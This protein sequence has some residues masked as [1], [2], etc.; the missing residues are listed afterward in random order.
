MREML[1]AIW[2]APADDEPRLVYA[3]WLLERG[4]PRG[5]LIQVQIAIARAVGSAA[6]NERALRARERQLLEAH[7][8]AW[9][10]TPFDERIT[11]AF[12]RG[13]PT[14]R[15]G[16]AGLF[17]EHGRDRVFACHR[18]FL[19]GTVITVSIGDDPRPEILRRVAKWF[20]H[21]YSDG[22]GYTASFE[23]GAA[24]SLRVASTSTA[25]TVD[26]TGRIH[27]ATLAYA[28]HSHI[29]GAD[30]TTNLRLDGEEVCDSRGDR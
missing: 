13:F 25:G 10:G 16:H 4:D 26:Y 23:P 7:Q 28:W 5:E 22:G 17:V 9:L 15:F 6:V 1:E 18:Y 21:G 29:N 2:A 14:G 19:D 8:E 11:W 30:G 24:P 3:D 27:G 20:V 12:D